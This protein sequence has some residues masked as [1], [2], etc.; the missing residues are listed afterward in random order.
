[1]NQENFIDI[2]QNDLNPKQKQVLTLLLSGKNN[3]EIAKAIDINDSSGISYHLRE[4]GKKFKITNYYRDSLLELF[5]KYQPQL[6]CDELKQ[7]YGLFYPKNYYQVG[8]T[9]PL[10]YPSY[11][12][13]KSDRILY[14]SLLNHEY[15]LV[16]NPRQ[17]GKSSLKIRTI[18]QIQNQNTGFKCISIDITL[19]GG[20]EAQTARSK[21]FVAEVFSQLNIQIEINEWWEKHNYLTLMQRLNQAMSLILSQISDNIIIF[22]DEIDS[23]PNTDDFFAFIRAC[24]NQ[25]AD[26]PEYNRLIFCLLGVTSPQDLMKNQQ[27]TPFNIGVVIDLP[28]FSLSELKK[29]LLTG[30]ATVVENPETVLEAILF[31]T[32]GQPFLTQKLC[33]LVKD[34]VHNKQVDVNG[35][36]Q[37]SIINSWQQNDSPQHFQTIYNYLLKNTENPRKIL[38]LYRKI[39][40]NDLPSARN[41]T[42]EAVP[43]ILSGLVVK[44]NQVLK[45][46]N[47]IYQQV[48][49]LDWL[50]FQLQNIIQ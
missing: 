10:D 35:I 40:N 42:N 4:I 39:L 49:N 37:Q 50:Q 43:L 36:V 30:I 32:G 20:D 27:R 18:D 2:Y 17:T 9:L 24:Y 44:E 14:N 31:W 3:H 5:I 41:N 34:H 23:I 45:I 25:R 33:S 47:P 38:D 12:E 29:Y 13:R 8:G 48:F 28:R 46:S 21:G 7:K 6:V 26:K 15:C 22:I 16:L 1:M 11:V 19:L